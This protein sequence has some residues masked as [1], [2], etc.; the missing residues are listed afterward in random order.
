[1][2]VGRLTVDNPELL[3]T[4]RAGEEEAGVNFS[5]YTGFLSD[6]SS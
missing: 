1:M 2:F 4:D 6:P 5:D 3:R